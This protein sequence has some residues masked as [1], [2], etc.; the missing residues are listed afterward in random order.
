MQANAA[1]FFRINLE[2]P[3]G[4]QLEG[5]VVVEFPVFLVLLPREVEAYSLIDSH[6]VAAPA[7]NPQQRQQGEAAAELPPL[8]RPPAGPMTRPGG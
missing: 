4:R 3:L 2:Q 8:G 1:Q 6:K 5:K 7:A